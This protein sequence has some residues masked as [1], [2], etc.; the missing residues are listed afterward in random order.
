MDIN[1]RKNEYVHFGIC[2]DERKTPK[3]MTK[4]NFI[5]KN[6]ERNKYL[7]EFAKTK[8]LKNFDLNMKYFNCLDKEKFKIALEGILSMYV[9][10]EVSNLNLLKGTKGIYLLVLDNYKQIYIGQTNRDIKERIL[11]HFKIEISFQ[12][13]PFVRY[14][15]LT[16]DAFKPLDTSRIFV[17][18]T[19]QQKFLMRLRAN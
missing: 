19:P 9:F 3:Y 12:K 5:N 10:I 16:I 17:L 18:F 14:D 7:T 6:S 2:F 15:T 1:L 4:E 8:A 13:V 11:R